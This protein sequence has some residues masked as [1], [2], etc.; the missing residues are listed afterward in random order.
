ML[1]DARP[2][3]KPPRNMAAAAAMGPRRRRTP[4]CGRVSGRARARWCKHIH[5]HARTGWPAGPGRQAGGEERH[6]PAW[7]P[8]TPRAM[9]T[10]ASSMHE[11]IHTRAGLAGPVPENSTGLPQARSHLLLPLRA[12]G[13]AARRTHD[14]SRA[15]ADRLANARDAAKEG[16]PPGG[17]VRG[18]VPSWC[19][20]LWQ[21]AAAADCAWSLNRALRAVPARRL[22][23]GVPHQL[24]GWCCE[25]QE[26]GHSHTLAGGGVEC[27]GGGKG[28]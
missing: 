2:V 10:H 23:G 6:A 17:C 5:K 9:H 8:D 20:C 12:A 25:A 27:T 1:L 15:P 11:L 3:P 19:W 26:G 13:G 22:H 4:P 7:Q 18:W 28:L 16:A 14:Q 24:H 21:P